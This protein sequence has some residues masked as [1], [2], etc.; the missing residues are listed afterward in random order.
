[1]IHAVSRLR[2]RCSTVAHPL[3]AHHIAHRAARFNRRGVRQSQHATIKLLHPVWRSSVKRNVI[4]PQNAR[5]GNSSG[6][7]ES[8]SRRKYQR[9]YCNQSSH[10]QHDCSAVC[11]GNSR[12]RYRFRFTPW[13]SVSSVVKEFCPPPQ[14]LP[15]FPPESSTPAPSHPPA[16]PKPSSAQPL[17]SLA[18]GSPQYDGASTPPHSRRSGGLLPP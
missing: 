1:V 11:P 3:R 6:L 10:K 18:S 4:D 13:S 15:R 2:I 14:L 8:A 5:P 9:Q 16:A 17:E 7:R 12:F